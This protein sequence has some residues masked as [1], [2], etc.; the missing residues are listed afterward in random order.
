M[1][2][3]TLYFVFFEADGIDFSQPHKPPRAETALWAYK[4]K[5]TAI[6]ISFFERSVKHSCLS[7][8]EDTV[9]LEPINV[10]Q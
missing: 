1:C 4:I 3:S 5:G 9:G 2:V 7:A 8:L 10:V 6:L